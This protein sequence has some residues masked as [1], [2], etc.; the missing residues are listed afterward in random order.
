MERGAKA[1][2]KILMAAML[3]GVVVIVFHPAYRAA[4]MALWRGEV[5]AS[6]VWQS[7]AAY[8]TEIGARGE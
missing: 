6:P 5:A 2:I 1:L 7:N 8:Y 4:F 3:F